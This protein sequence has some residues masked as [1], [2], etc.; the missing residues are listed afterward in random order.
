MI[1]SRDISKKEISKTFRGILRIS[2]DSDGADVGLDSLN[3]KIISDSV[4]NESTV[5]LSQNSVTITNLTGNDLKIPDKLTF[6]T[7][8]NVDTSAPNLND[9]LIGD[10]NKNYTLQN[11]VDIIRNELVKYNILASIVPVGTVFYSAM[12]SRDINNLPSIYRNDYLIPNGQGLSKTTSPDLFALLGYT[13]GGSGDT[14]NLPNLSNKFVRAAG[15]AIVKGNEGTYTIP[16]HNPGNTEDPQTNPEILSRINASGTFQCVSSKFTQNRDQ[17]IS[18]A[19]NSPT[20][21]FRTIS[22]SEQ[23]NTYKGSG[24]WNG[25]SVIQFSLSGAGQTPKETR[26]YNITLVPLIKIK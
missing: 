24:F 10:S 14:F 18:E 3:E 23:F 11:L 20:G 4:G 19:Q 13:F 16:A 26:P 5:S 12:K 9:I 2:P 8:T 17:A 15:D 1:S 21:A 7:I 25:F 6:N 22:A